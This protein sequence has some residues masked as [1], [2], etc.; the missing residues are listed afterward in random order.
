MFFS[1]SALWRCFPCASLQLLFPN[2]LFP[3]E[4]P[5]HPGSATGPAQQVL[6]IL[7]SLWSCGSHCLCRVCLDGSCYEKVGILIEGLMVGEFPLAQQVRKV[8]PSWWFQLFFL[9]SFTPKPKLVKI[10]SIWRAFFFSDGVVQ[11]PT[12]LWGRELS[13]ALFKYV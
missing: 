12:S 10:F 11:P 5:S 8:D 3:K 9:E 2:L 4:I 6:Q 13:G 1:T 7:A